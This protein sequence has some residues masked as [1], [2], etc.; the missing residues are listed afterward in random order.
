MIYLHAGETDFCVC[1]KIQ[2]T[3]TRWE[4]EEVG[5]FFLNALRRSCNARKLGSSTFQYWAFPKSREDYLTR[6]RYYWQ[7]SRVLPKEDLS[8]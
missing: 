7:M 4:I 8:T 2:E 3:Q 5:H 6:V 1:L